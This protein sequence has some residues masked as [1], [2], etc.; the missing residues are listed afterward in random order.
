M[1]SWIR[2]L[3]SKQ[4][5]SEAPLDFR[6]DIDGEGKHVVETFA[7]I[8][9]QREKINDVNEIWNYGSTLKRKGKK[10]VFLT[11]DIE[12]LLSMR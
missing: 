6:L 2:R 8:D 3:F 11:S 1:F 4:K 9:D 12:T 7:T 5:F 10:F